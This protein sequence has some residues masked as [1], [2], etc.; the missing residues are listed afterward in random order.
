MADEK[1]VDMRFAGI[2]NDYNSR[3]YIVNDLVDALSSV[4]PT[5]FVEI[6]TEVEARRNNFYTYKFIV[7]VNFDFSQAGQLIVQYFSPTHAGWHYETKV[8]D[9]QVGEAAWVNIVGE[10]F[11]VIKD[12][13]V[14]HKFPPVKKPDTSGGGD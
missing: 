9:R 2:I 11:Q 12:Y 7:P 1:N 8:F 5:D 3:V 10:E 4:T 13:K 6:E 14:I